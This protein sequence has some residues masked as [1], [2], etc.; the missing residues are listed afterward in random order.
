MP[1]LELLP[2]AGRPGFARKLL[3]VWRLHH[4]GAGEEVVVSVFPGEWPDEPLEV[5]GIPVRFD[6]RATS[7]AGGVMVLGRIR[8]S[9]R[10][11]FNLAYSPVADMS[12][13]NLA[14]TTVYGEVTDDRHLKFWL[15]PSPETGEVPMWE[16]T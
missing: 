9:W 11:A 7:A 5:K 16:T 13:Q 14:I 15:S 8:D 1:E 6:A 4:L 12:V 10:W 2:L 3:A